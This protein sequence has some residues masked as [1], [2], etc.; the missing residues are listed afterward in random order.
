MV[1]TAAAAVPAGNTKQ[2]I[3]SREPKKTEKGNSIGVDGCPVDHSNS[4]RFLRDMCSGTIRKG[5]DL[6]P[7][8]QVNLLRD[9]VMEKVVGENATDNGITQKRSAIT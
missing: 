8:C 3:S 2:R 6:Q 4:T 7:H 1:F 5:K 9:E